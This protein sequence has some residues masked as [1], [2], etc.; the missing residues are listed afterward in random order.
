MALPL[1]WTRT[2]GAGNLSPGWT[3]GMYFSASLQ[4]CLQTHSLHLLPGHCTWFVM[5]MDL[6]TSACLCPLCSGPV[7][8]GST[9]TVDTGSPSALGSSSLLEPPCFCGY[10]IIQCTYIY[11]EY[12]SFILSVTP[13]IGLAHFPGLQPF[14]DQ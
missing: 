9:G 5:S 11:I 8:L 10:L 13:K 1:Q 3:P 12:L 4:P 7:S 14:G 6:V 2:Y